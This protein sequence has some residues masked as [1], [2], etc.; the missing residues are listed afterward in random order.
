MPYK[1]TTMKTWARIE[2]EVKTELQ[3]WGAKAYS[4]SSGIAA[5]EGMKQVRP[6]TAKINQTPEEATVT[7][8]V[9]WPDWKKRP[10]LTIRY[11]K[12]ARAV[13]NAAA[14]ILTLHELRMHETRGIDDVMRQAY[15]QLPAGGETKIKRDP[16]EVLGV[17]KA[18]PLEVVDA[19]YRVL[20]KSA[21]PD[22]GGSD[23]AMAELNE[24][25][26]VVKA[27]AR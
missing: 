18:T 26:E 2:A 1:H 21:H 14:I 16:Y 19:A 4:L 11:N 22:A 7:L 27:S 12:Q 23:E 9:E 20:A 3:R 5:P 17:T 6:N 8:V 13:D 25:Y 24:A 15:M 10:P